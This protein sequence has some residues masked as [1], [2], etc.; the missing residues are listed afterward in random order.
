MNF[1]LFSRSLCYYL[2]SRHYGGH[3]LHSPF[4]YSLVR[5]IFKNK[6]D[7]SIV[8]LVEKARRSYRTD[9][10]EIIVNDPGSGSFSM[11]STRRKVSAIV[12]DE[13]VRPAY[14]KLLSRLA[15]IAQGRTI[16]ELGTSLG[17]GTMYLALGAR[18]SKVV[19][20]EAC[21]SRAAICKGKLQQL[22]I[23]KVEVIVA[24]F[25]GVLEDI[26]AKN[27][28]PGLVYI[29]GNRRGEDIKRYMEAF[30]PFIDENTLVIINDIHYSRDM[31]RV[32]QQLTKEPDVRVS[33][34]ILQF[35]LL[36]FRKGLSK[37][38]FIIRY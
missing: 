12:R 6:T 31:E 9:K 3:G 18:E 17:I 2:F 33:I 35:G 20:V 19:S 7:R 25:D 24:G 5:D 28:P 38:D 1:F 30:A 34:D 10:R 23:D 21:S 11:G 22:G 36:F 4:V 27:N 32:W 26:L 15:G 8:S 29:D 13:A 37:Q 16:I 14:G